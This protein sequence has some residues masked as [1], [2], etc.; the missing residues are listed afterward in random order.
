VGKAT[1]RANQRSAQPIGKEG[2]VKTQFCGFSK[3][4]R[5]TNYIAAEIFG[6][7]GNVPFS[8]VSPF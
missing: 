5:K 3:G 4:Q 8:F 2:K 6:T 1:S 7:S